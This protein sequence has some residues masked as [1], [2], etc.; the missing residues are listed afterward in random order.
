MPVVTRAAVPEYAVG[1][2]N[3]NDSLTQLTVT[4]EGSTQLLSLPLPERNDDDPLEE[5]LELP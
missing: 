2:P 1:V 4:T 5:T 3:G